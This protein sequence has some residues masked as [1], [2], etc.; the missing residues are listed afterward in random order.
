MDKEQIKIKEAFKFGVNDL[1]I[2]LEYKGVVY[3]GC[4]TELLEDDKI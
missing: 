3:C 4:I 1:N 2:T